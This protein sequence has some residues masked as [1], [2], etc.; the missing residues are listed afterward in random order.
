MKSLLIAFL[1]AFMGASLF[2]Q[3]Y[4]IRHLRW[5]M[6][7]EEAQA[8][9][10]P[11]SVYGFKE[12]LF[13]IEVDIDFVFHLSELKYCIPH[14][15]NSISYDEMEKKYKEYGLKKNYS[16]NT[17][18]YIYDEFYKENWG[19][20]T[21]L[22]FQKKA[23]AELSKK[24]G[25]PKLI[26]FST[27]ADIDFDM[28][29]AC[30]LENSDVNL[31]QRKLNECIDFNKYYK[32]EKD[33]QTVILLNCLDNPKYFQRGAFCNSKRERGELLFMDKK[34][35]NLLKTEYDYCVKFYKSKIEEFKKKPTNSE[36]F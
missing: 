34:L 31:F 24:Y 6:S 25:A 19:Y 10:S 7:E 11:N 29:I 2:S 33:S 4:N 30:F 22:N 17:V 26:Q 5:G 20:S 14:S 1:L 3:E 36:K 16:L 23:V 13:G 21:V 15:R 9:E 32:W 28:F 35:F 18:R 12:N 27:D 8:A